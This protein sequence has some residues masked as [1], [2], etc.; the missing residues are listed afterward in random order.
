MQHVFPDIAID[1]I[2]RVLYDPGLLWT[3]LGI[4]AAV[5]T[6]TVVLVIVLVKRKKKR[7]SQQ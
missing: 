4:V 1:P 6:A 7:G 3:I 5:I 2:E